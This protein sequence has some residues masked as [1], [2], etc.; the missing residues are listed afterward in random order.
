MLA[1]VGP[2]SLVFCWCEL[3]FIFGGVCAENENGDDSIAGPMA[4]LNVG[5]SGI[6]K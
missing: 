4:L 2:L 5:I 3:I 6:Q 1:M